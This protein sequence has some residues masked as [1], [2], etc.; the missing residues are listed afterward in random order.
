[1]GFDIS[2]NHARIMDAGKE[3]FTATTMAGIGQAVAGILRHPAETANRFCCVSSIKTSQLDILRAYERVT[4][5]QWTVETL[6][7]G[8][9]LKRGREM[10]EAGERQGMLDVLAV[11]LFGEGGGRSIGTTEGENDSQLLGVA[12]PTIDEIVQ[13]VLTA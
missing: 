1:M 4:G 8:K 3:P 2:T 9:V 11:Q 7:S 10:L 5:K 6:D 12:Q 13:E